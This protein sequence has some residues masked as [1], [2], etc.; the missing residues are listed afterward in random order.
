MGHWT[1]S[2]CY[3]SVGILWLSTSQLFH[4]SPFRRFQIGASIAC[5][6]PRLFSV[7]S[8]TINMVSLLRFFYFILFYFQFDYYFPKLQI[9]PYVLPNCYTKPPLSV[10]ESLKGVLCFTEKPW[11]LYYMNFSLIFIM[12]FV[13]VLWSC[14]FYYS[15]EVFRRAILQPGPPQSF[16]LQTVQEVIKPQ[17]IHIYLYLYIYFP[18]TFLWIEFG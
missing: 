6:L 4:S 13:L 18:C 2:T 5:F 17:V 10:T 16:A 12:V 15:Q 3:C 14:A 9:H 11:G 8:S 1:C 7:Q